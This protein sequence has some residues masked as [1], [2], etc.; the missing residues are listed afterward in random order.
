MLHVGELPKVLGFLADQRE[1]LITSDPLFAGVIKR[2]EPDP[3]LG[4]SHGAPSF[5][6]EKKQLAAR[7]ERERQ[8]RE[9]RARLEADGVRRTEEEI[10]AL[11]LLP[12][13]DTEGTGG[14]NPKAS[15][16]VPASGGDEKKAA[17]TTSAAGPTTKV[18]TAGGATT[19]ATATTG[20]APPSGTAAT[21]TA[22]SS[23]GAGRTIPGALGRGPT[24]APPRLLFVKEKPAASW[25]ASGGGGGQ[26]STSL[27]AGLK[28]NNINIKVFSNEG[29]TRPRR[30]ND[31]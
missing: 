7:R 13:S 11:L 24:V 22:T 1:K 18:V 28:S 23:A 25:K 20:D 4:S 9:R 5:E 19:T 12:S 29:T 16:L 6:E 21:T 8:L 30:T 3:L 31:P 17:I 27:L 10:E 14:N 2:D 26:P 15:Q